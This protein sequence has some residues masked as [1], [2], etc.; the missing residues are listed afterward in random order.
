MVLVLIQRRFIVNSLQELNG[1]NTSSTLPYTDLRTAD[2]IFDRTTADNQTITVNEGATFPASVGIEII[3]VAVAS[4][5]NPR[6]T[7]DVSS[8]PGTIVSWPTIPSGCYVTNPYPGVYEISGIE[9]ADIWDQVKSPDIILAEGIPFGYFGTWAYTSNIEYYNA[10][11]G[12]LSKNWTVTVTVLDVLVLT[13]PLELSY[14]TNGNTNITN[15][16]QII[17]VDISYPTTTWTITAVPSDTSSISSFSSTYSGGGT[18]TYVSA[19]KRF[20]IVGTR[21]QVNSHLNALRI[22]SN[23]VTNDFILSYLLTN[24]TDS[25]TDT[26]T[27]TFKNTDIEFLS[28]ISTPTFYYTEDATST[29]VTGAPTITDT[30]FA[31]T[32]TYTL[33]ITPSNTNAYSTMSSTG[34]GGTSSFNGTS[35]VLTITGTRTQVNSHLPNISFVLTSDF[36]T[37]FNLSYGLSVR[38]SSANKIQ[39]FVCGSTDNEITNMNINRNYISNNENSLFTTDTPVITDFDST[40]A[41]TYTISFDCSFGDW[42]TSSS[43]YSNPYSYSGTRAQCNAHFATIKFYPDASV[44]SNGTFTYT[45]LKNGVT[46]VTQSVGLFGSVGPGYSASRTIE[47]LVTQT[48]TPSILDAKYGKISEITLVGGG[49]GGSAGG[50]GGGQVKYLTPS[51]LLENLTYT[52]TIGSGGAAGNSN[53]ASS[54]GAPGTNGGNTTAFGYTALGGGGGG[55][56]TNGSPFGGASG[57]YSYGPDGTL[58]GGG[59]GAYSNNGYTGSNP[60]QFLKESWRGGGGAGS[61]GTTTLYVGY[62]VNAS[63]SWGVANKESGSGGVGYYSP[64]GGVNYSGLPT[65]YNTAPNFGFGGGG[66]KL[67]EISSPGSFGGYRGIPPT[68][69]F[70][71]TGGTW[72]YDNYDNSPN[73]VFPPNNAQDSPRTSAVA[74]GGGGGGAL[75]GNGSVPPKAGGDGIVI[76]K[77]IAR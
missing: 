37:T 54:G 64:L 47:F 8:L 31:G 33:T 25:N 66:G 39:Q 6:Y 57:G 49:G 71:S 5:S 59:T 11:L 72:N 45:Q 22:T 65:V 41:D 50:G 75:G 62:S 30:S 17:D 52:I 4:V 69:Y 24:N 19:T 38:S 34:S 21:A 27:Q 46:Q 36:A 63:G 48:W 67:V 60:T 61:G 20:T 74:G 77:I 29:T 2:V 58:Y 35:K 3:D 23:S 14:A 1:Y 53:F 44:S 43:S 9:T 10:T 28:N 51:Y 7:I 15:P 32:D 18:F 55:H 13:N 40:G 26:K 70:Y 76:I 42:G 73:Q 68:E 56:W 12:N 16:P